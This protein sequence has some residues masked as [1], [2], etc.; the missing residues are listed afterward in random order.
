[1]TSTQTYHKLF[2][3]LNWNLN[4][5][6]KIKWLSIHLPCICKCQLQWHLIHGCTQWCQCNIWLKVAA[7]ITEQTQQTFM[8]PWITGIRIHIQFQL[9]LS[10]SHNQVVCRIQ[11]Q[12][13]HIKVQ[14][15]Q[16]QLIINNTTYQ[17][18][19]QTIMAGIQTLSFKKPI[20]QKKNIRKTKNGKRIFLSDQTQLIINNIML[21]AQFQI[22]KQIQDT[23]FHHLDRKVNRRRT[24]L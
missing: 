16:I 22:C 5:N 3:T 11:D 18:H 12:T 4:L 8:Q 19:H 2:W 9:L 1:M 21:I 13:G 24:H 7:I 10:L 23:I 17:A 6:Q 20:L 14:K 15:D